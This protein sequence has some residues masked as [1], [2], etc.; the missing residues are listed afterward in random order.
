M[1]VEIHR[2]DQRARASYG[3]L[4]ARYSFSF[5]D[6]FNPV[7]ERFGVV[8]VLNEVSLSGGHAT[9][10]HTHAN[11][12]IITIPLKGDLEQLDANGNRDLIREGEVQ[13][14]SA[15]TGIT[16]SE[17]NLSSGEPCSFLQIWIFPETKQTN[18]GIS[19]LA[20]ESSI[21]KNIPQLIV[22]PE[23]KS[24]VLR[25]RQQAWMYILD[26]D[27][28]SGLDYQLN[29]TGNGLMVFV[30]EGAVELAGEQL[31]RRDSFEMWDAD[32]VT[33]EAREEA[34]LLLIEVP[35]D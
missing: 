20:F 1:K 23:E 7:R 15:G 31:Y 28:G 24:S 14:L 16:V 10:P 11:M 5:A 22:S 35:A 34:R 13:L 19:K 18:P 27:K 33:V 17:A 26:M 2:S 9:A 6:Y 8:R 32:R 30:I 3:W 21:R 12:E 4:E 29:R 25:I